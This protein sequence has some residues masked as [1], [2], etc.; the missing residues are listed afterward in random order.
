MEVLQH[1]VEPV[2][3]PVGVGRGDA[4]VVPVQPQ[5][6]AAVIEGVTSVHVRRRLL[7]CAGVGSP[8]GSQ[9]DT[10]ARRQDAMRKCV[11]TGLVVD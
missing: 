7:V 8:F 6:R 9:G 5:R 10:C 2:H 4:G 1:G 11:S 3:E